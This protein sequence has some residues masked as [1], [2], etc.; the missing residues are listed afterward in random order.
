MILVQTPNQ[1]KHVMLATIVSVGIVVPITYWLM[2]RT[3]PYVYKRVEVSPPVVQP[4]GEIAITFTVDQLRTSC[5]AGSVY[6]EFKEGA[7]GRLLII[8]PIQRA[9]APVIVDGKFTR[10]ARLPAT[11]EPGEVIYRGQVCY[12]CNPLQSWFRWPICAS[13]PEVKFRV[14]RP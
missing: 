7:T 4:G 2:D 1:V 10:I 12:S 13:T 6:R 9:A 14:E 5:S 8:D 11:I 3:P